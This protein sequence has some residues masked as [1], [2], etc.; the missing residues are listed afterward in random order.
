MESAQAIERERNYGSAGDTAQG[1]SDGL[2]KRQRTIVLAVMMSG[3]TAACISQSMMIA[4][5]PTIMHEY[6]VSA[7]LG[8][9][10]TTSYIFTLGLI[11]AMTAY[12]VHRVDSKKLFIAAMVCFVAGCAAALVAPNYPLL[13][14]SRLLQAGGA[15][16]ALPLIQVVALSVYPKSEYGRAMG[17]VGLIIGFAPAIGP[18]VSGFLIDFWGWRSVFVILGAVSAVVVVLSFFVLS[19]VVKREASRERF[20]VPSGLLYTLGFCGIMLGTTVMESDAAFDPVS[21]S[22]LAGGAL[23]LFVFARRQARIEQ[24]L[25]KLSCFRNRTFAIATVLVMM[26][27]MAF[28]VGS[29]MVPLFVQDVQGG[30]A[31]VS[32]L[33]ILPGAVLLGFL[34][35]VTGRLL[36]RY[37]PRPLVAVGCAVLAAGTLAFAACD[38]GTPEWAITVL[39]GVRTVGV[40]CLMMPMTAHACAALSLEDIAQGTAI[41]TS[42]RQIFGALSSSALITVMALASSNELGIDVGGFALSFEVQAAVIV[43]GFVVGMAFLPRPQRK[44][45]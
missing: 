30:S 28:M 36:D 3:T 17:L 21:L 19:D 22:A 4:A 24:P 1:V 32:G 16:I 38:A 39:Y 23:A 29:I 33:T 45:R 9:L 31:T 13:L 40:A 14:A 18:T 35:P 41:I 43:V 20:D 11:S 2:P 26:S 44:T 7:S 15:G 25:L 42:F 37:G 27:Q 34:N 5:L 6:S 8:Q 10:L 12:L